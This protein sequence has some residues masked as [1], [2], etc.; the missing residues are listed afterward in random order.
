MENIEIVN[1]IKK[2]GKSGK[3]S[4][5]QMLNFL[6]EYPILRG[7][8]F[9]FT[10]SCANAGKYIGDEVAYFVKGLHLIEKEYMDQTLSEF[11]FGSPSPTYKVITALQD[12]NSKLAFELKKW[13]SENGGNFYIDK[14]L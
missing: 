8:E 11:G 9:I 1:L 4:K 5:E 2:I 14:K 10:I 6:Q 3:C 13:V 12:T 7:S